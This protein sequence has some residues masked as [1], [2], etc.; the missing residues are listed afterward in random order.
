MLRQEGD[1]R[2]Q[3]F[4]L[5]MGPQHPS[6]HGVYRAILTMDG[7]YVVHLENVVGYLHRGMEKLAETRTY[8]QF[9]PY[10]DRLDYLA[11]ILNNWG[12]CL[13]VEKALGLEVPEKGEY[14][15]VILGELQRIA[16]HL[17]MLASFALDLSAWT[18]WMYPFY[19]REKILDLF[20]LYCGSRLT[21]TAT[22]IG[23]QPTF[24]C[25]VQKAVGSIFRL[26]PGHHRFASNLV[27]GNEIFQ[28]PKGVAVVDRDMA[29]DYGFT[30]PN[31]RASGVNFDLRKA[32][33]YGL[34][35]RF[36]FDVPL[37]ETGDNFDRYYLRILEMGTVLAH[38]QASL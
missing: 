34:Y 4:L 5:N 3:E 32:A 10:T 8:T 18:G 26:S 29:L 25:R 12:Y 6:T 23:G 15:R 2:T 27:T 36:E 1:F 21:T 9:I 19:D 37:G 28:G 17:V 31:L 22:R 30:G 38:R 11:G 16:S 35:G 20:E 7:E 13:T 33:P 24:L 14:I